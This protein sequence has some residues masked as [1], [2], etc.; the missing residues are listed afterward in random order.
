[1][2]F[3]WKLY[4]HN[5]CDVCI[6][7]IATDRDVFYVEIGGFDT[8]SIPAITPFSLFSPY[9]STKNSTHNL[10]VSSMITSKRGSM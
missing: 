9:S 7:K 10:L 2:I 1:M 5:F 3:F 6:S 4:L 8:V